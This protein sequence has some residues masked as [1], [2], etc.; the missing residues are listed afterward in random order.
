MRRR[1]TYFRD[2]AERPIGNVLG[3]FQFDENAGPTFGDGTGDESSLQN[4]G[5][6][7]I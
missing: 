6:I 5:C 7:T 2:V 4:F 3:G 1:N